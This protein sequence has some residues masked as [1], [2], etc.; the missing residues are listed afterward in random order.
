MTAAVV[1]CIM[2]DTVTA[3][4]L[5][6]ST[7]PIS[8]YRPLFRAIFLSACPIKYIKTSCMR[9]GKPRGRLSGYSLSEAMLILCK[10]REDDLEF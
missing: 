10:G 1:K 3:R 9:Y 7:A 4:K 2:A 5:M 6:V 8:R